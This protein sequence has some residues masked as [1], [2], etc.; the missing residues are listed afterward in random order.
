MSDLKPLSKEAIPA[1]LEKAGCD[2]FGVTCTDEGISVRKTGVRRPI[3]ILTSFVPGEETRL[4][5]HDLTA[6]IHR[7]QQLPDLE[8]AAA[9]NSSRIGSRRKQVDFHLKIDT[10][11]NRLGVS[12]N[13]MECFAREFAK[14]RHLRLSGVF[15]HFASSEV[16]SETEAGRQTS[17]QEKVWLIAHAGKS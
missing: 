16:F 10:G 2:W 13:D 17:E 1:A 12:P 9:R 4:V 3:L 11:M 5:Q 8:R 15:T 6:V 7:C 14:C